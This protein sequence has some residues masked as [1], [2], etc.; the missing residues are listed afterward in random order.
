M[1]LF[2][3]KTLTRLVVE[4][5]S[6]WNN[7]IRIAHGIE[8][9]KDW[10]TVWTECPSNSVRQRYSKWQP[11]H[12]LT[13][14]AVRLCASDGQHSQIVSNYR[15]EPSPVQHPLP[16]NT[17]AKLNEIVEN[18]NSFREHRMFD[19]KL[20]RWHRMLWGC[21]GFPSQTLLTRIEA[22]AELVKKQANICSWDPWRSFV[23]KTGYAL[24]WRPFDNAD[25]RQAAL[26]ISKWLSTT[27]R[28]RT[29]RHSGKDSLI[30][31]PMVV[32]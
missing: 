27:G 8:S 11:H 13:T 3:R 4:W 7:L 25:I 16:Q 9:R 24:G 19:F 29:E 20:W 15:F 31:W 23:S 5:A 12:K 28:R 1:R 17:R 6:W 30:G 18:C 26:R 14:I 10:Y 22:K 2:T 21:S 32:R